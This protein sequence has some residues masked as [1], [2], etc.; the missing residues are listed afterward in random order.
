MTLL[1][2]PL[3]ACFACPI[4][5]VCRQAGQVPAQCVAKLTPA[6]RLLQQTYPVYPFN[7]STELYPEWAFSAM[8][9]V[10]KTI[11]VAVASTLW[12]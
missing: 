6:R 5:A 2:G 7:C 9:N 8:P 1:S 10:S 3:M 4:W 11:Q 12:S